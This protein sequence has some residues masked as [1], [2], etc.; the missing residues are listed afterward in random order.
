MRLNLIQ[1]MFESLALEDAVIRGDTEEAKK[2]LENLLQVQKE[3]HAAFEPE[4][5][6]GEEGQGEAPSS[7]AAARP[8]RRPGLTPTRAL[9]KRR[10]LTEV[11]GPTAR[12]FFSPGVAPDRAAHP[13]G[14]PRRGSL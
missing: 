14:P 6:E 13:V 3:G 11:P 1:A 4:E 2:S 12:A 8:P 9:E 7:R 10:V 5:E